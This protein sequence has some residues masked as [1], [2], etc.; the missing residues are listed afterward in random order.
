MERYPGRK[1]FLLSLDGWGIAPPSKGNAV[2]NAKT[3]VMDTLR[4]NKTR[5]AELHASGLHVGLPKDVMG[6]SEVGHLTM[7]AG[8]QKLTDLVR[9]DESIRNQ[10]FSKNT[11]LQNAF[12]Y[13]ATHSK[14]VHFLGLVSD[15]RVHSHIEHL[16]KFI[17]AAKDANVD[18]TYIHFFSDGRDTPPNSGHLYVKKV[19]DF[20]KRLCYAELATIIGRYYSMDRDKR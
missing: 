20:T 10:S 18:K 19:L 17:E 7:G 4:E 6:N 14:R 9:I 8:R 16:F 12:K 3:P 13:A 15:G 5:Y 11:V 2:A 1:V